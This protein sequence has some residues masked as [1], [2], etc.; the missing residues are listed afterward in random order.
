MYLKSTL[1]LPTRKAPQ[2]GAGIWNLWV[3]V[4]CN[5]VQ[6]S[7]ID[8]LHNATRYSDLRLGGEW[9]IGFFRWFSQLQCVCTRSFDPTF[10]EGTVS[11]L[12]STD[13]N[14]W[15]N[16][17]KTNDIDSSSF[18][19]GVLVVTCSC[20]VSSLCQCSMYHVVVCRTQAFS[21]SDAL[22]RDT[23]SYDTGTQQYNYHERKRNQ[24]WQ[25][26]SR[27]LQ[28]CTMRFR[29]Q[30]WI[31]W[32]PPFEDLGFLRLDHDSGYDLQLGIY[33]DHWTLTGT[34]GINQH[35]N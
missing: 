31:R 16:C 21:Y 13:Q 32:H 30:R 4:A 7:E 35:Q 29:D 14:A 28:W 10:P 1:K 9:Y 24:E 34:L 11:C 12:V 17:W 8:E 25:C 5:T 26:A 20:F 18:E 15:P 27:Y 22:L 33:H 2:L 19:F 3:T 6:A 23:I